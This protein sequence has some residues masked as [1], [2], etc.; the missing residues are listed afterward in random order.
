MKKNFLNICAFF[1]I[2]M[3]FTSCGTVKQDIKQN[4]IDGK[5][6]TNF[7]NYKISLEN[8]LDTH[9][10]KA[11]NNLDITFS[12][13]VQNG[14]VSQFLFSSSDS[15]N[16]EGVCYAT[17]NSNSVWSIIYSNY[18]IIDNTVS[19]THMETSGFTSENTPYSVI[20]GVV[21]EKNISYIKLF[22]FDGKIIQVMPANSGKTY[23][24]V[25]TDTNKGVKKIEGYSKDDKLIFSY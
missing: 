5:L 8:Y 2:I 13:E 11:I 10:G 21:N 7:T 23:A 12:E 6:D 3:V 14:Y 20:S 9:L 18:N 15:K 25:R 22:Y 1:L 24:S 19:F 4:S 17:Y 16:Y